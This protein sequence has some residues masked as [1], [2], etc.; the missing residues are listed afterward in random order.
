VGGWG[1]QRPSREL[2]D[3]TVLSQTPSKPLLVCVWMRMGPRGGGYL[4]VFNV[5]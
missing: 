4:A 2:I 5:N 3:T 1:A